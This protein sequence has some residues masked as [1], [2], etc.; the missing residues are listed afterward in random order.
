MTIRLA[1]M[2]LKLILCSTSIIQNDTSWQT[3]ANTWSTCRIRLK[4]MRLPCTLRISIGAM[5]INQE[6]LAS[7]S[8]GCSEP[9]SVIQKLCGMTAHQFSCKCSSPY[10]WIK[11]L[12]RWLHFCEFQEMDSK[13]Y[14][15]LG[16]RCF[17]LQRVVF[18]YLPSGLRTW[19]VYVVCGLFDKRC[20][21]PLRFSR[22]GRPRF[23]INFEWVASE[24][25]ELTPR[26][27]KK[28]AKALK[29]P[30]MIRLKHD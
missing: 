6:A 28:Q 22:V 2:T 26:Y 24:F 9:R 27:R 17:H 23:E 5:A 10:S 7:I 29:P 3:F 1:H 18:V 21:L 4:N 15:R 12:G 25:G 11:I 16:Q 19:Q 30:K 8:D 14:R 13:K 20:D